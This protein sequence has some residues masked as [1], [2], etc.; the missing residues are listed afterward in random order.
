MQFA[1]Q[2]PRTSTLEAGPV[3][4]DEGMALGL[5]LALEQLGH[6]VEIHSRHTIRQA[7]DLDFC[8]DLYTSPECSFRPAKRNVWWYQAPHLIDAREA[9]PLSDLCRMSFWE[10]C[11]ASPALGK[12]MLS[13]GIEHSMF[14]PMSASEALWFPQPRAATRKKLVFVGNMNRPEHEVESFFRPLVK[15]GLEIFG[16]GWEKTTLPE[17]CV[18]GLLPYRQVPDLYASSD[19]VLSHHTRWHRTNDVPTS[20]LFEA[21]LC[22]CCIVSDW[23]ETGERL[24]GD[25]VVWIRDDERPYLAD[26]VA[27]LLADDDLRRELGAAAREQVVGKLSFEAHAPRLLDWMAEV[28]DQ[29]AA[30]RRSWMYWNQGCQPG[31]AVLYH[32][33]KL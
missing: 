25:T 8:L 7:V 22:G 4:G 29:V 24:L 14:L 17:S 11:Y 31:E 15:C 5:K 23:L 1:I 27:D 21:A 19:L 12:Q 26:L 9:P 33:C 10:G 3:W 28:P 6:D 30:D 20:R 2:V 32:A 18:K 16:A 13:W